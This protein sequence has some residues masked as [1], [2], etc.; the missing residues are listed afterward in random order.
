MP[1]DTSIIAPRNMPQEPQGGGRQGMGPGIMQGL[2]SAISW[3]QKQGLEIE[4][5]IQAILKLVGEVGLNIDE[6]QV[7]ALVE[8]TGGES[9]QMGR[10]GMGANIPMMSNMGE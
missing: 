7:R 4:D 6:E 8:Q 2:K 3:L 9:P 5:I 10:E 1:I